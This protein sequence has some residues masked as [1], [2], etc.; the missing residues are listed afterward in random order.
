M[1]MASSRYDQPYESY[2]KLGKV[3]GPSAQERQARAKASGN[4]DWLRMLAG[5][6]PAAGTALGA[7]AGALIGG[8]PT[9]GAGALPGA[10]I[11]GAIGGGLGQMAGGL[12]SSNADSQT[13]EF[14]DKEAERQAK[15]NA[16]MGL[17]GGRR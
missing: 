16:L 13:K 10:G 2:A 1:N 11:G 7:G 15:L 14:D 3:A 8:I 17:L 5:I 6:A 4:A 12:L 9:G